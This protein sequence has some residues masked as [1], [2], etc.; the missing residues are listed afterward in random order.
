M[1]SSSGAG[2]VQLFCD[3]HK[4]AKKS[5]IQL[6][7]IPCSPPSGRRPIESLP[8]QP[9][10]SWL[11]RPRCS[12]RC[13]GRGS[14]TPTTPT[15]STQHRGRSSRGGA[16]EHVWECAR[17][18]SMPNVGSDSADVVFVAGYLIARFVPA[19]LYVLSGGNDPCGHQIA[20]RYA[21]ESRSGPS[22]GP[23]AS[24]SPPA[25]IGSRCGPWR[26]RSS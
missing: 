3:R 8:I 10:S 1:K 17:W 18:R 20:K 22:A 25:M 4:A 21:P 15:A 13:G 2:D 23:V 9:G 6:V 26:W 12:F 7:F 14:S 19:G 11:P 5:R 24:S 16:G